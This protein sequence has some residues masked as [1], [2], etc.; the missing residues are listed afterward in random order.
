MSQLLLELVTC[1]FGAIY[2]IF[3]GFGVIV[4]SHAWSHEN[5]TKYGVFWFGEVGERVYFG[6]FGDC[7]NLTSV[8]H[9]FHMSLCFS[10]AGECFVMI[11]LAI[12]WILDSF[13]MFCEMLC[14]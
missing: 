10:V 7:N 13:C 9:D 3:G 8:L 2:G 1:R 4:L 12:V 14:M 5:F 6:V 11:A